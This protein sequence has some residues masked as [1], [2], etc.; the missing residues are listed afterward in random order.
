MLEFSTL[1]N[2]TVFLAFLLVLL[3]FL[4]STGFAKDTFWIDGDVKEIEK[5]QNAEVLTEN[6][7]FLDVIEEDIKY[8]E[9]YGNYDTSL[10][11]YT[12]TYETVVTPEE[13]RII[14]ST[15]YSFDENTQ[16][17][18][19]KVGVEYEDE[20]DLAN[21]NYESA[22]TT[23][24]EVYSE[25][26]S[27]GDVQIMASSTRTR[28]YRTKW[29]DPVKLQVNKVET[30]LKYTYNGT[31]VTSYTAS[32]YRQWLTASGWRSMSHTLSHQFLNNKNARANTTTRMNN[33][34]FCVANPNTNVYY[35]NNRVTGYFN[36]SA[37][38]SV[39][40]YAN[41]GCSS[42]LSYSNSLY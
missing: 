3:F 16:T 8:Y 4:P 17:L 41:G 22:E 35:N 27:T 33:N 25:D 24:E 10:K 18:I 7:V 9:V 11:D 6:R 34:K 37:A 23:S 26:I 1:K 39:S 42:W 38:G 20:E 19:I 28:T 36:G 29:V 32:D 12:F 40:T 14:T 5:P 21:E 15:P 2:S 30:T 13:D 31:R